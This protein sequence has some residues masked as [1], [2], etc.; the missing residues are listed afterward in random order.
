MSRNTSSHRTASRGAFSGS[1]AMEPRP[2]SYSGLEAVEP[3]RA[4][5]LS[6]GG[7]GPV[8]REQSGSALIIVVLLALVVTGLCTTMLIT[9]NTDR[10]ISTNERDAERALFASKAGLNYAYNL[11]K[12]KA[13]TPTPA[14]VGFNSFASAVSTP[15][16]GGAFTGTFYSVPSSSGSLYKIVSTGTYKRGTRTTELVFVLIPDALQYGYLAFNEAKLHRH[17][18]TGPSS[19]LIQSTIFSNNIVSIPAGVTIDGSI[20]SSGSIDIDNDPGHAPPM[21]TS[22]TGDVYSYAIS[23]KGTVQGKARMLT[24]V[25]PTNG[26]PQRI[27]NQG[28][29]YLWYSNRSN[30]DAAP[31]GVGTIVGGS[32]RYVI[33]DGDSF[34]TS[35]FNADG[36]LITPPNLNVIKYVAAPQLDYA[37]MK[38]EAD[39]NDATYFTSTA[40]AV[41]YMISKKVTEVVGGQ[42]MTTVKIGT[43]L[44]PEFLY[45]K[46][47]LNLVV[48]PTLAADNP[49]QAKI[50]AD[51]LYIEGG[52]YVTG[53][54]SFDGRAFTSPAE[55]PAGYDQLHVNALPYCYPA[56][57]AYNEPSTGSIASWKPANTPPVGS[58]SDFNMSSPGGDYGGST[59]LN[60]LVYVQNQMHLHHTK[61]PHEIIRFNGAELGYSL[62]N[63]D[64]FQ[65]TYDSAV[66]CTRFL[67]ASGGSP[68][69]VS[70]RELR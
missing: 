19:F 56:I 57:L 53:D 37:A 30:P 11:Y 18:Q 12:T 63:C 24:S 47:S 26:T 69:I 55:N 23:N 66:G 45:I 1:D 60:G 70:Y 31:T 41:A 68:Q 35:L 65:F 51:G 3:A 67:G 42:T 7:P 8:S 28:N 43:A 13:L 9:S 14:G 20:V 46:G 29:K 25:I 58:G 38:A 33:A 5:T 49:G 4:R 50:K 40:T 21:L 52:I 36:T 64:F 10:M 27:D 54:F 48:D 32:S 16:D 34:N 62:H 17:D 22:V 15:L 6:G 2:C 61:D 59:Y 44:A 39:L